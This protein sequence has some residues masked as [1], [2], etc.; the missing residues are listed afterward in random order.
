MI[1]RRKF[2]AAL[3]ATGIGLVLLESLLLEQYYFEVNTYDIGD[4]DKQGKNLRFAQ[5]SDLHLQSVGW[6]H[7]ELAARITREQPDI[8]LL[9]GDMVD[10]DDKYEELDTFLSLL[11][12]NTPKLAILGN[13]EYWGNASGKELTDVYDKHNVQLLVNQTQQLQ[14]QEIPVQ[15]TGVDCFL[16]GNPY[17]SHVFEGVQEQPHHFI[18]QHCPDQVAHTYKELN[19]DNKP[20]SVK[21]IFS[22]HT[23]GGQITLLGWTPVV[24]RGVGRF[25]RGWHDHNGLKMYVSKGFGTSVLPLRFCAR[26]ELTFFDYYTG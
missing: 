1:S 10:R 19:R 2:I 5:L 24:P 23:H 26:A 22:G 12:H 8:I 20:L 17:A 11:P 9:T 16:G 4:A 13:W 3:A 7:R 18:L 14:L 21:Y 15:F 25:L 6:H